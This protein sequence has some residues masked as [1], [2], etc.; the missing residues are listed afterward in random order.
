[1][2]T[3][4][5]QG[6][7]VW[8]VRAVIYGILGAIIIGISV[9]F[10]RSVRAN[11]RSRGFLGILIIIIQTLTLVGIIVVLVYFANEYGWVDRIQE[12]IP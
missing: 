7:A 1:M 5:F 3:E 4:E 6:I 12:L 9:V 8:I 2:S 10:I 11:I